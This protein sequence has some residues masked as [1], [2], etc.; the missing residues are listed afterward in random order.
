MSVSFWSKLKNKKKLANFKTCIVPTNSHL[1]N[2]IMATSNHELCLQ[3][4]RTIRTHSAPLLAD[5]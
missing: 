2:R 4:L 1:S 3:G 5:H